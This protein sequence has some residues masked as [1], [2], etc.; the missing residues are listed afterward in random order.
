MGITKAELFT[1]D[2]NRTAQW[3]KVLGHPARIAILQHILQRNTCV[4][5]SLVD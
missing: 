4:C 5:G 2:Q 3:A 1:R